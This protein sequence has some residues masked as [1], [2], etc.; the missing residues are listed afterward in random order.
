MGLFLKY[1]FAFLVITVFSL[2]FQPKVKAAVRCETQ[3]GGTQICVTTG[4]LQINKKICDP[5]QGSCDPTSAGFTDRLVDNLGINSHL[6]A[7]GEDVVFRLSIKNVGDATIGNVA[8]ADTPQSGFFQLESGPL[9]F[10]LTNL[11]PGETRQQDIRLKVADTTLIPQNNVICVINAAETNGDDGSH[12][13][14]T[15]Q[16]CLER[17]VLGKGVVEIPKTGLPPI[18]WITS[19]LFLLIGFK[20]RKFNIKRKGG[21]K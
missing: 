16:L 15:A 9:N 5:N 21:E 6:F 4:Q 19:G 10:N 12:D 3:Y 20:L 13:R 17:K 1:F 18:A 8:V 14:D 11:N 2:L 7:P